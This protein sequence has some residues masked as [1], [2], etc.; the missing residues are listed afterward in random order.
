MVGALL[1]LLLLATP[2]TGAAHQESATMD[3][4][5]A[6]PHPLQLALNG[7][8]KTLRALLRADGASANKFLGS[9]PLAPT[10][11]MVAA[12]RGHVETME[13]LLQAGASTDVARRPDGTTALMLAAQGACPDRTTSE[14]GAQ[15]AVRTLLLGGAGPDMR[16]EH[17]LTA[18]MFAARH[19]CADHAKALLGAGA[20]VNI[21]A[22][23]GPVH[24]EHH[25]HTA[26][27]FAAAGGHVDVIEALL[28]EDADPTMLAGPP[29]GMQKLASELAPSMELVHLLQ[30]AEQNFKG[31]K[32]EPNSEL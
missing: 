32:E 17:G 23:S 8:T 11:L 16:Q 19:G 21:Q 12:K 2:C 1:L 31:A 10:A 29:E 26:L 5:D 22:E 28:S 6:V 20:G 25:L 27:H 3:D 15:S 7:D 14:D 30:E 13:T 4:A 18:L 9:G 24:L